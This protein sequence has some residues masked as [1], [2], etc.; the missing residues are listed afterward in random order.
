[1]HQA[2]GSRAKLA[3]YGCSLANEDT[4]LGKIRAIINRPNCDTDSCLKSKAALSSSITYVQVASDEGFMRLGQA[5]N[6]ASS[7]AASDEY[8]AGRVVYLAV[9]TQLGA[10]PAGVVLLCCRSFL[11]PSP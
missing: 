3:V 5:L 6:N 1:M 8:L 4:A 11:T 9:D 7:L 2:L 10:R